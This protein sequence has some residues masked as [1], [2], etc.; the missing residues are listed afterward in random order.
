MSQVTN[1]TI[2][3]S[4]LTMASLA[5]ALEA[6]FAALG[7]QNR[8]DTAPSNPYEG[9]LWWDSSGTPTEIL[10]RYAATAGWVNILSLNTTTG[11]MIPYRSGTALGTMATATATDYVT[12]A[13]FTAQT[14]LAAVSSGTP[15]AVE[16]AEDRILGRKTGGNIAAL[17]GPEA[18]AIIGAFGPTSGVAVESTSGTYIDFTS[19]PSWAKRITVMLAGVST[20]GTANLQVQIGDAGGIEAADYIG[21]C[22]QNGGTL[23]GW[24]TGAVISNGTTAATTCS[25]VVEI[26][27]LDAATNT[28]AIFGNSARSDAGAGRLF[29]GHKAL[30]ATLDRA[31]ITT[32]NGTDAF[33]AGLVNILYE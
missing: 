4:P 2:P 12:K 1:M 18:R 13:L 15:A 20:N 27:L 14:I 21:V 16:V 19:I 22:A 25:A 10:K 24:S 7:S 29:A 8:G 3:G 5:A 11:A 17:T 32:A 9:M 30:S 26:V 6:V 31:R 28:W 33:D 23:T